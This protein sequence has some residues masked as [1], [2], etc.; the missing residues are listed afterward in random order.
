M[1]QTKLLIS[2]WEDALLSTAYLTEY[3]QKSIHSTPYKLWNGKKP[4]F[5]GL[6]PWG[7]ANQ[8]LRQVKNIF[9][10]YSK[11][12]KGYIMYGEHPDGGMTGIES[13]DVNFLGEDSPN[14]GEVKK[15]L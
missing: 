11:H 8:V 13:L 3:P 12:S 9:I 5:E 10:T 2:F 15:D 1:V 6:R 7:S 14:I 4:N